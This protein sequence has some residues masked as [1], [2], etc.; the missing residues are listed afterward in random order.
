MIRLREIKRSVVIIIAIQKRLSETTCT[1][2]PSLPP[3]EPR[4]PKNMG[5]FSERREKYKDL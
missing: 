5:R 2:P 4:K 3:H 1:G